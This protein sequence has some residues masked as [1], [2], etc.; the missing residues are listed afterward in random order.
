M[1]F[2]PFNMGKFTLFNRIVMAPLTRLRADENDVPTALMREYYSQ[3]ATK[4]ALI[5]TEGAII[6]RAARGF[7]NAPGIYNQLQVAEWQKITSAVHAKGSVIFLQL[8]HVGLKS[9]IDLLPTGTLPVGPSKINYFGL[10]RTK[11]GLVPASPNRA[12]ENN[13][14]AQIIEDYR[15]AS[16]L[17][18]EAGFDGVE[19]HGANGYLVDLFLQDGTNRRTDQYGGS[20]ENRTRFLLEVTQALIDVWGNGRVGVRLSPSG[21]YGGVYDSDPITLFSYVAQ[22]LN[23]FNLAYL[24]L[25]E[26]RMDGT[27]IKEI[28]LKP[29]AA[30]RLRNIYK[31]NIIVAGGFSQ[32]DA[33]EILEDGDAD[34]VAF[35]RNFIANPDLIERMRNG[36]SLN[37]YDRKTFIE[38]GEHGYTDYPFY[39][40]L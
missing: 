21:T 12:L 19:L 33:E 14:I 34:L 5:I 26:P 16:K 27:D 17:A 32:K 8:W 30:N 9:H 22:M 35:G 18:K 1:L 39:K 2:S 20:L 6:S 7:L 38:G 28:G 29:V 3:R 24:H 23:Q 36:F 10:A 37:E 25:I 4:G 13:E 15:E 31:G 40:E 11:N